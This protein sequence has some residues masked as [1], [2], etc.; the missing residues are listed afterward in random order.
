MAICADQSK[1]KSPMARKVLGCE[2]PPVAPVLPFSLLRK[3]TG[4]V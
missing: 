4:N 2:T 3:T 1:E